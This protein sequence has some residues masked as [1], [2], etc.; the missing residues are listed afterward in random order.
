MIITLLLFSCELIFG[1]LVFDFFDSEKKFTLWEKLISALLIGFILSNFLILIASLVSGSIFIGVVFFSVIFAFFAGFFYFRFLNL[2]FEISDVLSKFRFKMK[3]VRNFWLIFFIIFFIFYCLFVAVLLYRNSEGNLQALY[4]GDW[5]DNAFHISLIQRFAN[6]QPF[7]LDHPVLADNKLTYHFV[8][9]FSS[10]VLFKISNWLVF[11]YDLPLFLVSFSAFFLIFFI[12]LRVLKSSQFAALAVFLIFIGSGFGFIQM[13]GDYKISYLKGGISAVLNGLKNP[14]ESYTQIYS[15]NINWI[16]P[17]ASFFHQRSSI[18]GIAIFSFILLS[19]FYYAN[20]KNFWRFGILAGLLPLSQAHSFISL[21]ILMAVLFWFYLKNFKSWMLFAFFT[22][23]I[24]VPQLLYLKF[25]N[26]KLSSFFLKPWFGW[27]LCDHQK[28]WFFCEISGNKN[29]NVFLFWLNNFGFILAFW[30]F[31]LLLILYARLRNLQKAEKFQNR[32]LLSSVF[33]FVIPNL[34]LFQPWNFDNNKIIFYWWFIAIIAG[35]CPLLMRIN[36]HFKFWGKLVILLF[37]LFST[38][39]GFR[40][41]FPR[42]FFLKEYSFGYVDSARE[43][44]ETAD[45]IKGNTSSDSI[46]ISDTWIDNIP[47]F[48]AGR[49]IYL[50][51]PGW[52]WTEGLDYSKNQI[53]QEKILSGNMKLACSEKIDYIFLNN[54]IKKNFPMLNESALSTE[55]KVVFYKKT[56]YD[57]LKILKII[58]GK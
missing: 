13:I 46:F 7:N 53:K 25:A 15:A 27:M 50:G 14:T 31:A 1:I 20:S 28:S 5:G 9:D 57:N 41:F 48:L 35:V 8:M 32:L 10:A 39:A 3:L 26:E 19:I 12:A 52:L 37:V 38:L 55:T 43:N 40:D 24:S 56:P 29:T 47:L 11:S 21:F 36:E 49:K 51:Y 33:L 6:S 34:F 18:F 16:T 17:L 54:E 22:A 2:F 45:W 23:L 30:L 44:R 4:G 42:L 58:C